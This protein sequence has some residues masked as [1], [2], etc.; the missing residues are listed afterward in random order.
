ME[1]RAKS[2]QYGDHAPASTGESAPKPNVLGSLPS[3]LFNTGVVP[4][5]AQPNGVARDS[6]VVWPELERYFTYLSGT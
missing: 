6:L 4:L 2:H 5:Q 3:S 1:S